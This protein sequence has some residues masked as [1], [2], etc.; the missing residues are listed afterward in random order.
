MSNNNEGI[1]AVFLSIRHRLVRQLLNF[2]PPRDVEDIV[3]ETYVR[4][5]QVKNESE[6][7]HPRS[8]LL[9]TAKNLAIDHLKSAD[10]RL[11]SSTED[12]EGSQWELPEEEIDEPFREVAAKQEFSDFC[13]AVRT[14]PQQ[15]RKVFVLKKVYGHS[16]KEI[17][18]ELGISESTVEKHIAVGIKKCRNYMKDIANPNVKTPSRATPEGLK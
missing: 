6:I 4:I 12:E 3:Q 18:R 14:L 7:R 1:G 13:E 5:C 17:A 16:Q 2:M 10:V 15:C 9:R 8:F 11:V